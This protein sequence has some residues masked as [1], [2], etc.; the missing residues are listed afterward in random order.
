MKS[1]GNTSWQ[2]LSAEVKLRLREVNLYP[3][4]PKQQETEL[5]VGSSDPTPRALSVGP[6]PFIF[7]N[8][9]CL[10]SDHL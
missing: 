5:A 8:T 7:R 6:T 3:R 9:D 10:A 4:W 1:T 2:S